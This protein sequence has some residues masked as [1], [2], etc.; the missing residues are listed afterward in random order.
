MYVE[1]RE[2]KCYE[3][4]QDVKTVNRKSFLKEGGYLISHGGFQTETC[5]KGCI[6]TY[7]I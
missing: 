4:K 5:P 7:N 6:H 2:A 1:Q 3:N